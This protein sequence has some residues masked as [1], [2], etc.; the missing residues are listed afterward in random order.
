[1]KKIFI[2]L[3]LFI[4]MIYSSYAEQETLRN[5]DTTLQSYV[6]YPSSDYQWQVAHFYPEAPCLIKQIKI[7]CSGNAGS[8]Q[9]FIATQEAGSN[10]PAIT[11][12]TSKA[13]RVLNINVNAQP[14]TG[15]PT[16]I[17][18]DPPISITGNQLFVGLINLS[19]GTNWLTDQVERPSFCEYT[20]D[21][22]LIKYNNSLLLDRQAQWSYGTGAHLVDV[23]VDYPTKTPAYHFQDVTE[24]YEL[25]TN[26]NPGTIAFADFNDDGFQDLLVRGK[27]YQ[28]NEG[29]IFEDITSTAGLYG[30]PSANLFLDMDNDGDLDI[31]FLNQGTGAKS[32]IFINEGDGSFSD[33]EL[34]IP[35]L[36][37]VTSY[38]VADVNED[39]YPDLF[40]G[41]LW[42]TKPEPLP[43]YMLLNNKSND[44]TDTTKLLYPD[45]D[46]TWNYPNEQWDPPNMIVDRNRSSRGSQ[47][48]DFDNDGDLDLFVTNYFLQWDEFYRNNGDGTFSDIISQKNIDVNQ[49]GH[50]HGTGVDWY[51]YDNDGDMD[52][53]LSQ[54]AF[55]GF[56]EDYDHRPM[57]IYKNNGAPNYSFTDTYNPSDFVSNIGLGYEETYAGAAWGDANND[58]LTDLIATT[59]NSCRFIDFYQQSNDHTFANRTFEYG[60]EGIVTGED[61]CWVDF[62]NDGKLDLAMSDNRQF[63]LFKNFYDL[64]YDWL[65]VDLEG[66]AGQESYITGARVKVYTNNGTFTQEVSLG[67]GQKMQKPF[68]LHFGLGKTAEIEK[69][70]VRWPGTTEYEVFFS[71]QPNM[72]VKLIQDKGGMP[73]VPEKPVLAYPLDGTIDFDSKADK[74]KWNRTDNADKYHILVAKDNAFSNVVVDNADIAKPEQEVKDLEGLTKYYWKVKAGNFVGYGDWSDIWSFTTAEIISEVPAKPLLTSPEDGAADVSKKNDKFVWQ[75]VD[76]ADDYNLQV[77]ENFSFNPVALDISGITATEFPVS[78]L[79]GNTTFFWRVRGWNKAGF[80]EWSTLR[81]FT[82][83][84]SRPDYPLAP[85]LLS[86]VAKT[87]NVLQSS[88]LTWEPGVGATQYRIQ[89]STHYTMGK[90]IVVDTVI[91]PNKYPVSRL[92]GETE[93]FWQ[94]YSINS[95]G[96]SEEA[97]EVWNFTTGIFT[98]VEELNLIPYNFYISDPLPN[99]MTSTTSF[100]IGIL[101]NTHVSIIVFDVNGRQ[102]DRILS[103]QMNAGT[104]RINWNPDNLQSGIYY[105]QLSSGV[106]SETK[107]LSVV[108]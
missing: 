36:F 40:I 11:F 57:T 75:A 72:L 45:Y 56:I 25:P 5:W 43:N 73:Q 14:N 31:L 95:R 22:V 51:D 64:N 50:N 99:P 49:T 2:L 88:Y 84:N 28:N 29:Q 46:G 104:Y 59:S 33:K 53:L 66:K 70:E 47:F 76:G 8:A 17:D 10:I 102:V 13:A 30:T 42:K 54:F 68:R 19:N 90:D 81:N 63:R 39:K 65:E 7:Y 83:D 48:V 21:G 41:Q 34:N 4:S 32:V 101:T 20:E 94:V 97:S 78:D 12:Y 44:F 15:V 100:D 67:R 71:I 91:R 106:H 103:K 82:T 89:V 3:S 37:A 18:I 92:E 86:P 108:K 105:I 55:P 1:M 69:V 52:L 107:M 26:F 96:E 60:L 62:D 61:A 85:A 24:E 38:S 74:I 80:G 87:T 6:Y 16:T 58:G 9:L 77:A 23:I 98:S 35:E 93:Y 27:L 79:A